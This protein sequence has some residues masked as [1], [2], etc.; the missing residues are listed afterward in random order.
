MQA[1]KISKISQIEKNQLSDFYRETYHK[2]YKSLTN[3]W[4]WWYRVGH[5]KFEPLILLLD[6]KVIGQ[7]GL[8]PV[9]LNILKEKVQAIYFVDF[10][11]LPKYQ[12]KGFGKI[13]S[14]EWMKICP[15]QITFCNDKSLKVFKKLGWKNDLSTKRLSRPINILKFL[16]VL[17]S[18]KFN[19]IDQ[20]YLNIPKY[21]SGENIE[22]HVN[23]YN[24]DDAGIDLY[25]RLMSPYDES[26]V[27]NLVSSLKFQNFKNQQ[28]EYYCQ[29]LTTIN[30]HTFKGNN[31]YRGDCLD[32]EKFDLITHN[33]LDAM[34][35]DFTNRNFKPKLK[36][37]G[38]LT[39]PEAKKWIEQ[40]VSPIQTHNNRTTSNNASV[41]S[42]MLNGSGD[43]NIGRHAGKG[44][45]VNIYYTNRMSLSLKQ[46]QMHLITSQLIKN[47]LFHEIREKR[48]LA[49]AVGSYYLFKYETGIANYL[50]FWFSSSIEHEKALYDLTHEVLDR[51]NESEIEEVAFDRAKYAVVSSIAMFDL[52]LYISAFHKLSQDYNVNFN[53]GLSLKDITQ[54]ITIEDVEKYRE[55]M[56]ESS[57]LFLFVQEGN[58]N[59]H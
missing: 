21:L 58:N 17:K 51:F 22:Y 10:A 7:A 43:Y 24:V 3:N 6:N 53:K 44:S 23:S 20:S 54:T 13:L 11:I 33:N 40:Y 52:T 8:L 37:I 26:T 45:V 34:R 30:T 38:S 50:T 32:T 29:P 36:I 18:F 55:L 12:R 47:E 49:Y 14:K 28:N 2:R 46:R 48:A 19:F 35:L 27:K 31:R 41:D 5:S 1:Y 9:D 57:S 59:Q 4:R 16:P 42:V 15:N 25:S 56:L 39:L